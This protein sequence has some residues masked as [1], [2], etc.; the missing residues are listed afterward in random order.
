MKNKP[1]LKVGEVTFSLEELYCL[2]FDPDCEP[3]NVTNEMLETMGIAAG[4]VLCLE[5]RSGT[6]Q[7][8][9]QFSSDE[10]PCV[11]LQLQPHAEGEDPIL[12]ARA[13][14]QRDGEETPNIYL[15]GRGDSYIAKMPV[16]T[17]TM[18]ELGDGIIQADLL[19]SGDTDCVVKV[20]LENQYV[21]L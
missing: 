2:V 9:C 15:Y 3:E 10:Y 11:E 8:T 1:F 17:R 19:V 12:M 20:N 16:D 7:A 4:P 6:M 18:E 21:T 14:Q 5:T 13:E